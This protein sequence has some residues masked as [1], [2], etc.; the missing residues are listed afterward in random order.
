MGVTGPQSDTA[1]FADLAGRAPLRLDDPNLAA[2]MVFADDERWARG[3]LADQTATDALRRLTALGT[4]IFTRQQVILRPGA[5]TLLLSGNRRMFSIDIG[6]DQVR[7]WVDDLMRVA[8][9]AERIPAP[10]V[11]SQ[12]TS[13]EALNRRLRAGNPYLALWIGLGF[14]VGIVGLGILITVVIL[15]LG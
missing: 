8:Q 2:L 14:F 10:T 1:W 9:A 3:L 6:A 13:A 4:S 5:M 7:L 15:A 11:T 12:E